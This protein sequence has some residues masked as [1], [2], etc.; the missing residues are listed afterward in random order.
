MKT[1]GALFT[2]LFFLPLYNAF[3]FIFSYIA[4]KLFYEKFKQGQQSGGGNFY[5]VD[6]R[7]PENQRPV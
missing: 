6:N 2:P 1:S 7:D 3:G 5:R 4:A